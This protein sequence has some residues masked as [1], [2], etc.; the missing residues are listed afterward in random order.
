MINFI[1]L[2]TKK[3]KKKMIRD[4]NHLILNYKLRKTKTNM[5]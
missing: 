2:A 1:Q 4:E 5:F 3:Q